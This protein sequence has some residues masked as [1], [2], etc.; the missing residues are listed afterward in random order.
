MK[1]NEKKNAKRNPNY[2]FAHISFQFDIAI[3]FNGTI[4]VFRA[5]NTQFHFP[6]QQW[7]ITNV[8]ECVALIFIFRKL[9]MFSYWCQNT[10]KCH[11]SQY[12]LLN[13]TANW[14]RKRNCFYWMGFLECAR[15]SLAYLKL[16]AIHLNW[17]IYQPF[18][19]NIFNALT[20]SYSIVNKKM[21]CE[22]QMN[23]STGC[24]LQI[25]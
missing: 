4:P 16:R 7:A 8:D 22:N 13:R 11:T 6:L 1:R 9:M 25:P 15:M 5:Q 17:W 19:W 18:N 24:H 20:K 12:S 23:M 3:Y 10:T 14:M 2:T 21:K